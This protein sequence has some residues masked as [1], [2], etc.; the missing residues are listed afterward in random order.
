MAAKGAKINTSLHRTLILKL[1]MC[2]AASCTYVQRA[3]NCHYAVLPLQTN[4]SSTTQLWW[5]GTQRAVRSDPLN[6]PLSR[7]SKHRFLGQLLAVHTDLRGCLALLLCNCVFLPVRLAAGTT[8]VAAI[9]VVPLLCGTG[10]AGGEDAPREPA[11]A[12]EGS[13]SG[14]VVTTA[15]RA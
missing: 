2:L 10:A 15:A 14:G 13:E 5:E 12:S 8:A 7:E 6:P 11:T 4:R 3:E 9:P 1:C